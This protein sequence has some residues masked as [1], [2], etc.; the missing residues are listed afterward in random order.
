M[1]DKATNAQVLDIL[2]K[3]GKHIFS[4]LSVIRILNNL[5]PSQISW[6]I[7]LSYEN[8]SLVDLILTLPRF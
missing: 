8:N 2:G 5:F 3:T 4:I 6:D 1:E 7:Y